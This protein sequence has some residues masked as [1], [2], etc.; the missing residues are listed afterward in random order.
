MTYTSFQYSAVAVDHATAATGSTIVVTAQVTNTGA[1]AGDKV[2]QL[3]IHQKA[4]S[5]SRPVRELKGFTRVSL[6]P[7][8]TK[9]VRFELGPKELTYWSGAERK[10][11]L[12]P[13]AFD[14]WVGGDSNAA[15][16]TGF[17]LTAKN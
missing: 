11:V 8:E 2:A 14:V 7:G 4:G 15:G 13:E 16:H 9:T 1:R 6:A 12:E 5:A 17:Q 3:Y 10:W